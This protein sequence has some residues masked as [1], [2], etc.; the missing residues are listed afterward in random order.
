MDDFLDVV[1]DSAS[2]II[3]GIGQNYQNS[4]E[5]AAAQ[6]ERTKVNNALKAQAQKEQIESRKR[7]EK[8]FSNILTFLAFIALIIA[9]SKY[10]APLFIKK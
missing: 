4:A 1:V 3:G 2:D 8:M 6:I 5:Y 9:F 10:L 7:M